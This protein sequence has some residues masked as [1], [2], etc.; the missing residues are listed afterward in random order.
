MRSPK[1]NYSVSLRI[2]ADFT[3][4][5]LS[6]LINPIGRMN[7]TNAPPAQVLKVFET[8]PNMYL[9][10]SPD[11]YI[12]TASDLYLEATQT[13]RQKLVGR[14]IFEAFPDNPAIPDADGVK[15]IHA[16]LQRV[17][18]TRKPDQM[19]VQHYDVPDPA[20]PGVF[21]E[22]YWLPSHTPVLDEQG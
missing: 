4:G 5:S 17:L 10:L 9:I 20:Q 19:P 18:S 3:A 15:N 13:T 8:V 14:H 12:L 1:K 6:A 11:L 2:L 16:S 21:L 7:Y 22:R